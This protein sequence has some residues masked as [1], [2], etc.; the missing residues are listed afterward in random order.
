MAVRG[1]IFETYGTS[2][3]SMLFLLSPRISARVVSI[4]FLP[5]LWL[6]CLTLHTL[7][8]CRLRRIWPKEN[9]KASREKEIAGPN[10]VQYGSFK[11]KHYIDS[12]RHMRILMKF[13]H[14]LPVSF[15]ELVLSR[16]HAVGQSPRGV[17]GDEDSDILNHASLL[18]AGGVYVQFNVRISFL[19]E[20]RSQA[21]EKTSDC[22]RHGV[23]QPAQQEKDYI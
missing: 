12:R 14:L 15:I 4:G 6:C 9:V 20:N 16:D 17:Q 2:K 18:K 13:D 21:V 22:I 19:I 7:K 3:L 10:N 11:L 23:F 5:R 1:M 8:E